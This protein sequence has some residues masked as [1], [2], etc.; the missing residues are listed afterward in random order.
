MSDSCKEFSIS[1]FTFEICCTLKI[2]KIWPMYEQLGGKM[3]SVINFTQSDLMKCHYHLFCGIRIQKLLQVQILWR[4]YWHTKTN[5]I[6]LLQK[7]LHLQRKVHFW[8]PIS[9]EILLNHFFYKTNYLLHLVLPAILYFFWLINVN[10][11]ILQ[12]PWPCKCYNL[13]NQRN[14]ECSFYS[15]QAA[16]MFSRRLCQRKL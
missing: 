15:L 3:W 8:K 11:F 2:C 10:I 14:T 6:F 4:K 12:M 13:M 1:T 9:T 7:P 5:S 16:M